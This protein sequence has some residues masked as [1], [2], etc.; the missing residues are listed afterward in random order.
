MTSS[1]AS[2]PVSSWSLVRACWPIGVVCVVLNMW[3]TME[4]N[5]YVP[6]AYTR[7]QCCGQHGD[8]ASKYD[9]IDKSKIDKMLA[10]AAKLGLSVPLVNDRIAACAVPHFPSKSKLWS[11]S[12]DCPND[13]FVRDRAQR[14]VSV[15]NPL[16][17]ATML[18]LLPVGGAIG[19]ACGRRPVLL[20]YTLVC[21]I[22]CIAYLLDTKFYHVWG[23]AV[24][25][26]A[27]VLISAAAEPKDAIVLG[28]AADLAGEDIS[29]KK[30]AV[31]GIYGCFNIGQLIGALAS[32]FILGTYASSYFLPWLIYACIGFC[33]FVF[34]KCVVPETL[35][36]NLKSP[37]KWGMLNP[38]QTHKAALT[39][40]IKNKTLIVACFVML[41]HAMTI[42]GFYTIIFSYLMQFGFS[43]QEAMLPGVLL[44]V[45]AILCAVTLSR[46]S[47]S[48][49]IMDRIILGN[50]LIIACMLLIGPVFVYTGHW[51]VYIGAFVG[52]LA[53]SMIIPALQTLVSE[54]VGEENQAKGQSALACFSK[55]GSII[56]PLVWSNCFFDATATGIA[57]ATPLF[58]SCVACAI[59]TALSYIMKMVD[60]RSAN[61]VKS[62]ASPLMA[63]SSGG[64]V[65]GSSGK[66]SK[67]P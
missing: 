57:A 15:N 34:T 55:V 6:F 29:A 36:E 26:I 2:A 28:A 41:V 16:Q 18:L 24:V 4:N 9:I 53:L 11:Q 25:L 52:G 22:A 65:Y 48:T 60:A 27:G 5:V 38:L 39:I 66:V 37:F 7:V 50:A 30:S 23:D 40:I 17:S 47:S 45:V 42:A 8:L 43:Q 56:G 20:V 64:N 63:D 67:E 33:I 61:G 1:D 31:A 12:P 51:A 54:R 32:F 13:T 10:E 19:D 59:C 21:M 44:N 35:P 58:A 46:Y 49:P 14:I 3:N 62:I